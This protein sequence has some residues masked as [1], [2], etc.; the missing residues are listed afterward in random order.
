MILIL[1]GPTMAGKTTLAKYLIEQE[2]FAYYKDVAF[3]EKSDD[4]AE[5]ARAHTMSNI[6]TVVDMLDYMSCYVDII[7]DRLHLS[8]MVYGSIDRRNAS[9]PFYT[10]IDQKLSRK[11]D[12]RLLMLTDDTESFELRNKKTM[13]DYNILY[14]IVYNESMLNKL[15]CKAT[16]LDDIQK[17]LN[18]NTEC[19]IAREDYFANF[20]K[21]QYKE[22]I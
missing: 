17:F 14:D 11:H 5:V 15:R 2:N 8:E 12:V 3:Y 6:N 13:R 21:E 4:S 20:S 9:K 19:V 16:D 7:I 10:H 18:I 22:I 1:E